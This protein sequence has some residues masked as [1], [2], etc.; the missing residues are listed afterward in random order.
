MIRL[1]F[2]SLL[3]S[4]VAC[5]SGTDDSGSTATDTAEDSGADTS[6][7]TSTDTGEDTGEDT[8]TMADITIQGTWVDNWGSDHVVSNTAWMS[9][10]SA[11]AISV[12]D[13]DGAYAIAQ[14]DAA[15]EWSP[16]LWSRFDWGWAG[17]ELLYCQTAYDKASEA[18][19]LATPAA[20][21]SSPGTGCGGFSWSVL[22]APL[23]ISADYDDAWGGHHV[24]DAFDWRQDFGGYRITRADDAAQ[25]VVAQNASDNS[26][27]PDLWSRF[28]W[29]WQDDE[30]YYCQTA[31]D[32][33]SE[34][35]ALATPAADASD[36]AG[37]CGGFSWTELREVLSINGNWNDN[38]GSNHVINAFAWTTGSSSYDITQ[39]HDAEGW[40]VAQNSASNEW[41]PGLWSRFDWTWDS[42]G[43]L[44]YCQTAY[45]ASTE[46]DAVA[47]PAADPSDSAN[48]GCGGF[49]WSS[50]SVNP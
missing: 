22:R 32:K 50:L 14:N 40:L 30:L 10:S 48:T 7:D 4:L 21:I 41:S 46:A 9:G 31:Y 28:D 47:T 44:W 11:F 3:L 8:G 17:G 42:E 38:W 19:A 33:A 2:T 23:S 45:A 43:G 25:W 49:S 36:I 20:D 13:N 15:N 35:D 18:D 5:D 1:S 26:W 12:Y 6:T 39:A 16:G 24:V 37:G 29:A 34:A 27:N